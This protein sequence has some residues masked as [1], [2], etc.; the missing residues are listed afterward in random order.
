[1]NLAVDRHGTAYIVVPSHILRFD[2]LT[3]EPKGETDVPD[4]QSGEYYMD[5]FIALNGNLYA[6]TGNSHLITLGPDGH[7]KNDIDLAEKVGETLML[8]KVAVL[9]TGEIFAID[10]LKGVF[11]FAP[12]GRYINRF[13]GGSENA[14]VSDI[15]APG[16]LNDPLNIAVDGKGRVYISNSGPA[17]EVFNSDGQFIDSF[18]GSDV[19]F[20]ITIDDQ[21]NIY[22][23]FRNKHAIRKFVP[24]KL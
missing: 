20:G 4:L 1:M 10:R 17:V 9:P 8:N 3:G 12:D 15:S 21:N 14:D 23:C 19:V 24:A 18:G 2:G 6:L 22:A 5:A 16:H 13:G 7:I 11:K